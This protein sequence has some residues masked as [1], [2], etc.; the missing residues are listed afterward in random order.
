MSASGSQP[1]SPKR[2]TTASIQRVTIA[3]PGSLSSPSR[4]SMGAVT[5]RSV[6][7]ASPSRKKST[8]RATVAEAVPEKSHSQSNPSFNRSFTMQS[9]M[10]QPIDD[11]PTAVAMPDEPA[12]KIMGSMVARR[13]M[14]SLARKNLS[15][16]DTGKVSLRSLSNAVK[17]SV[18]CVSSEMKVS[19]ALWLAACERQLKRDMSDLVDRMGVDVDLRKLLGEMSSMYAKL[20]SMQKEADHVHIELDGL[21][22]KLT[23]IENQVA[24]MQL[25]S[26]DLTVALA[27]VQAVLQSLISGEPQKELVADKIKA[28]WLAQKRMKNLRNSFELHL[29]A[30]GKRRLAAAK[31]EGMIENIVDFLHALP[32]GD[33]SMLDGALHL[34][35]H[36]DSGGKHTNELRQAVDYSLAHLNEQQRADLSLDEVDMDDVVEACQARAWRQQISRG[37]HKLLEDEMNKMEEISDVVDQVEAIHGR[38][39][40]PPSPEAASVV[41]CSATAARGLGESSRRLVEVDVPTSAEEGNGDLLACTEDLKPEETGRKL[42]AP[43]RTSL[44]P[45][46]S[47]GIARQSPAPEVSPPHSPGLPSQSWKPPTK[48]NSTKHEGW[49]TSLAMKPVSPPLSPAMT[50]RSLTSLTSDCFAQDAGA[51]RVE[52]SKEEDHDSCQALELLDM[53]HSLQ[54][55]EQEDAKE[56]DTHRDALHLPVQISLPCE[57]L[58]LSESRQQETLQL[59]PLQR[60]DQLSCRWK[61]MQL[62]RQRACGRTKD[63]L[64]HA[65]LPRARL[66]LS[67][68]QTR[69]HFNSRQL[70]KETLSSTTISFP[71]L[72]IVTNEFVSPSCQGAIIT[73]QALFLQDSSSLSS[74]YSAKTWEQGASTCSRSTSKAL[75]AFQCGVVT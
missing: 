46:S 66:R 68:Y 57:S 14:Y 60:T 37:M 11:L 44:T 13:R 9:V 24:S 10:S 45:I 30:I 38:I 67:G 56:E 47:P 19:G 28:A 20:H 75:L 54:T 43:G 48:R 52:S 34:A 62:Q 32:P 26:Q 42:S 73:A 36:D 23:T 29:Q 7:V 17:Q 65:K 69:F 64:R 58:K 59:E 41:E 50:R 35:M 33:R 53:S 2:A 51:S 8:K 61:E 21:D 18:H 15:K 25:A 49:R 74:F 3:A 70:S 72:L 16:D 55:Q 63:W 71:P 40:R 12:S 39:T 5:R 1:S 27:S 22:D 6:G 4:K 31:H